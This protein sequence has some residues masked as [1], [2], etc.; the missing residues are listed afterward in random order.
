[1]DRDKM[2]LNKLMEFAQFHVDMYKTNDILVTDLEKMNEKAMENIKDEC[3]R[4]MAIRTTFS[5]LDA[6]CYYLKQITLRLSEMMK[7]EL[8]EK[9][10]AFL[11]GVI[12]DKKTGK[13][14]L[15]Q[16]SILENVKGTFKEFAKLWGKKCYIARDYNAWRQFC[17]S[18]EIRHRIT[19]PAKSSDLQITE[20]DYFKVGDSFEWFSLKFGELIALIEP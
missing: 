11:T 10:R 13:K 5:T 18:I 2:Y 20:D 6:L 8:G 3:W 19:H 1:M 15:F 16:V 4:R 12:T 9:Q 14:K 7:T 17:E